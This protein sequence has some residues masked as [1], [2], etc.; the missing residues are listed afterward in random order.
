E[1]FL[2]IVPAWGGTQLVP[3]LA[4]VETAV[5]VI[6]ANPLR[7][8]RLLD[9]AAAVELGLADA[10]FEPAEFLDES[11]AFACE[12]T[13]TIARGRSVLEHDPEPV[14]RL[15]RGEVGDAVHGAAPAP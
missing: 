4:G 11:I 10:V 6:V 12:L 1:V 8:N 13:D 7:Q 2:G 9:A 3:R 5:K 15:A 14:L